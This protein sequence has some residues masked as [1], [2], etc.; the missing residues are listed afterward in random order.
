M[1]RDYKEGLKDYIQVN[2]RLIAFYEKF[3]AGSIQSEI[4]QHT[5]KL[6]V[7]RAKA[8][9]WPH[10]DFPGIGH[11]SLEIPGTTPYTRGSEL[12]NAETSA[13]GRALAALGFEV[14]KSVATADEIA[15]KHDPLDDTGDS[16]DLETALPQPKPFCPKCGMPDPNVFRRDRSGNGWF[17]WR[18]KG[19]CGTNFT[20]AEYE[21]AKPKPDDEDINWDGRGGGGPGTIAITGQTVIVD[22]STSQEATGRP[23]PA[24]FSPS[25]SA[26]DDE[27]APTPTLPPKGRQKADKG[28]SDEQIKQLAK[29]CESAGVDVYEMMGWFSVTSIESMTVSQHAMAMK[30]LIEKRTAKTKGVE[31]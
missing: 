2:E 17:C 31:L 27:L 20:D 13:W 25:Q 28:L 26:L 10:D 9:R 18:A 29:A 22:T 23:F 30:T 16:T 1:A 12:E 7:V 19:G 6:V 3:P 5:D 4:I 21:A 8:F 11:S 15:N 24:P 14:R